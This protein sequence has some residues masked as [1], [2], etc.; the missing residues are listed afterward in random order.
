MGWTKTLGTLGKI[1]RLVLPTRVSSLLLALSLGLLLGGGL[2][3]LFQSSTPSVRELPS[4]K[5]ETPK[6]N[7]RSELMGKSSVYM[8]IDSARLNGSTTNTLSETGRSR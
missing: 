8:K 2:Q 4:W 3:T 6:L 7:G 1:E 5:S